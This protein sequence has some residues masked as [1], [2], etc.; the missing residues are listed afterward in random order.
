MKEEI[1]RNERN[2]KEKEKQAKINE[3]VKEKWW[4]VNVEQNS[5]KRL[6]QK[7]TLKN[8]N[9]LRKKL[10]NK[11]FLWDFGYGNLWN[12][13]IWRFFVES[14]KSGEKDEKCC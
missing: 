8:Q 14:L 3:I 4:I 7:K 1:S 5:P 12:L 2:R 13:K 11:S 9:K 6:S 10:Q